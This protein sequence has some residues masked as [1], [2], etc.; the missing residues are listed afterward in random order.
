A[1]LQG[2]KRRIRSVRNTRQI[3]KAMQMVE[4]SKLRKTQAAAQKPKDYTE[5]ARELLERLSSQP[6]SKRNP[7]F[8]TRPVKQAL[9]ILIAGDRGMAGAYNNNALKALIRHIVDVGAPQ[10]TICIGKRASL[11]VARAADVEEISSYN[12][13]H[14]DADT[15]I[16]Q[17]VLEEIMDLFDRKEVDVVH[18]IYTQF[19]SMVKQE[20]IVRQL[21]PVPAAGPGNYLSDYEPEP[22]E[23]VNFAVRRVLEA[24][25]T[26]AV[27]ESRASEN[28]ARMVAM[29]NA[30]DNADD[31]I[32]DYTLAFNNAR[33]A[34]ITQEIAEISGGA[35]AITQ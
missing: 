12:I 26:Q 30:T 35:E 33:Q 22:E 23:F 27:L 11:Q 10:K 31:L 20:V 5:A 2:I 19:T 32:G 9:T 8:R 28:A 24:D 15:A 16:A 14:G 21:L 29:M 34:T 3:T 4:A 6:E 18:L 7:L 13:D 25:I 1:A 17:P